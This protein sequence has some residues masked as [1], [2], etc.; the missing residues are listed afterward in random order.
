MLKSLNPP[1]PSHFLPLPKGENNIKWLCCYCDMITNL[2]LVCKIAK[3]L[4]FP[5]K[6]P[7]KQGPSP[8]HFQPKM[9]MLYMRAQLAEH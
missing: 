2:Q 5:E 9:F 6:K 3:K 4:Q 8:H 1:P 7:N